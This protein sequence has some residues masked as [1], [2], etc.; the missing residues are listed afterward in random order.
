MNCS[1]K[2][3]LGELRLSKQ[4]GK[5]HSCPYFQSSKYLQCLERIRSCKFVEDNPEGH[6]AH[7][8]YVRDKIVEPERSAYKESWYRYPTAYN[9]AILSARSHSATLQ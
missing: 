1:S 6:T 3:E 2:Q 7:P 4:L 9:P 8:Y 5:A